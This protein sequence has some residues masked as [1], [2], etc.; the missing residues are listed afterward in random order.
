MSLR[1]TKMEGCGNDYV[2]VELF[3]QRLDLARAPALAR[4]ISDR[5]FGVGGDGLILVAPEPGASGRMIMFNQDGS[6]G[7]MCGNGIRC[8]ARLLHDRGLASG[9]LLTIATDAGPRAVR[10]HQGDAQR[11]ATVAMG[12]P[13]FL[14][15]RIPAREAVTSLTVLERTF[16]VTALSMGNPH[17]V[18]FLEE[19]LDAFAV[20]RFGPALAQHPVFPEGTNVEFV[21]VVDRTTLAQ[22]TWER[23]SGETLA[24]GSGACA[25]VVAGVQGGRLQAGV[26]ALVRL[27]GGSLGVRWAADGVHLTGP[28]RPVFDGVWTDRA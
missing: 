8:V 15:E 4:A 14:P 28:A 17:C 27:R 1:F 12:Q 24:C 2:Y 26:E 18:V 3:T 25:A 21:A 23:G 16:P 20:E 9:S 13:E 19:D 11:V 6:R 7:R 5:H 22:R 10:L